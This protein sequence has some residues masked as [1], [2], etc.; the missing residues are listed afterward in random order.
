MRT[1]LRIESATY[2]NAVDA[3]DYCGMM[4]DAALEML[5]MADRQEEIDFPKSR[6]S[7]TAMGS[8]V[9][10]FILA[11]ANHELECASECKLSSVL[12][13]VAAGNRGLKHFLDAFYHLQAAGGS[14]E[15][16]YEV[17]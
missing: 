2:T 17:L 1:N 6:V 16:R 5:P 7:I 14:Y 13:D 11:G 3:I 8:I 10:S 15:L 4:Y 9:A 12:V